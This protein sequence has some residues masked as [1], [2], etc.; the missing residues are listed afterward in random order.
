MTEKKPALLI[1]DD[2]KEVCEFID[3]YFKRRGYSVLVANSA[4]EAIPI[5]KEKRPQ[6]MLLDK[7]MPDISGIDLLR[8]IRQFNQEI[9]VIMVSADAPDPTTQ[10]EIKD[11]CICGY[12]QK[13]VIVSE[14]EA[15]VKDVYW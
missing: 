13:P 14:L 6:V 15:V 4:K 1:V 11:L 2:E 9:K 12:L 7:R 8:D 5:I 3:L 10:L